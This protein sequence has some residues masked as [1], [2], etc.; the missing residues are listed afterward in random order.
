MH[1]WNNRYGS[2]RTRRK[3]TAAETHAHLE[4]KYNLP[5]GS[6]K[7]M[8]VAQRGLCPICDDVL[9]RPHVDHDHVSGVVRGILCHRCNPGIGMLKDSVEN[10]RRAEKYLAHALGT[11]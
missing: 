2:R 9:V 5:P 4:S 6:Y 1:R 3:K 8:W 7:S 10:L 11:V